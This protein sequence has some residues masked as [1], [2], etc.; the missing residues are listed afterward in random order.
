MA[1]SVVYAYAE[2]HQSRPITPRAQQAGDENEEQ[3]INELEGVWL[4]RA[5]LNNA[6]MRRETPPAVPRHRLLSSRHGSTPSTPIHH[7]QQSASLRSTPMHATLNT[8]VQHGQLVKSGSPSLHSRNTI[9]RQGQV[10]VEKRVAGTDDCPVCQLLLNQNDHQCSL[11]TAG[12]CSECFLCVLIAL[13][14]FF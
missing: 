10:T 1:L 7:A 13:C 8:P 11:A 14:A 2:R 9:D 12:V 4:D 5:A 6:G 3:V